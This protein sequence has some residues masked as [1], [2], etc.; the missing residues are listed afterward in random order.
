MV[1]L[2]ETWYDW[3]VANN[4][5]T[6]STFEI[7]RRDRHELINKRLKGGGGGAIF[8][9]KEF[10]AK[11]IE[12]IEEYRASKNESKLFNCYFECVFAPIL[13]AGSI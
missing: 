2:Q 3:D 6:H 13:E 1:C 7:F 9:N 5:I 4:E 8:A 11:E 10:E 12:V